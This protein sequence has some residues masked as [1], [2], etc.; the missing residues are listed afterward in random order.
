M[1]RTQLRAEDVLAIADVSTDETKK[2]TSEDLVLAGLENL[3]EGALEGNIIDWDSVPENSIDGSSIKDRSIEGVK[4]V[5]DTVTPAELQDNLPGTIIVNEGIDTAQLADGAVTEPKIDNGAVTTDKIA[6][7]AV[8]DAKITTVNGSKLVDGSVDGSKFDPNSF[9]GG[10]ELENNVVVHVNDVTAGSANGTVYD[11][12]GHV[13][14]STPILST[15]L[16]IATLTTPGAVSVPFEGGINVSANGAITHQN[17]VSAGTFAGITYDRHGHISA[18]DASGVVPPTSLPI[19]G[20]TAAE[21]GAVYI[22][23]QDHL[24]VAAD[25]AVRHTTVQGLATGTYTKVTVDTSGHVTAGEQLTASDIPNIEW[26]QINNIEI[27]QGDLGECAVESPNICDY[28]T[29]LMQ[30]TFPGK[31]DF[32]GQFWYTP[33]S[34]QLKVYSRG[35]GTEDLWLPVGFG[36][37]Q[38]QNLRVGFTYNATNQTI[39]SVTSYGTNVGLTAGSTVPPASEDLVGVYGVCVVA[40]NGMDSINNLS[41][42]THSAGD[43]ILCLGETQG[44]VHVDT[45]SSSGGSGGAQVLDDLLDVEIDYTLTYNLVQPSALLPVEAGQ[46]LTYNGTHWTNRPG[47][48]SVSIGVNPPSD[49]DPGDMWFDP[50][51]GQL[52]IW[53]TDNDSS[54]WVPAAPGTGGGGG[55]GPTGNTLEGLDDVSFT[56]DCPT[57]NG[58]FLKYN[59][60]TNVWQKTDTIDGGTF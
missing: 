47:G 5:L 40:G 8:T 30:E 16:P 27:G 10:I 18:V 35:S 45:N 12:H 4:L 56:A 7:G 39:V 11:E 33:S 3:P 26:D 44:W 36:A 2:I 14:G 37:L 29:C 42:T 43:W 57:D 13:T 15:E 6:D 20:D 46:V 59:C 24:T 9:G 17:N 52:F 21:L 50:E 48:G 55:G 41:G 34:A 28:A 31:G 53:Y 60:T 25:G 38:Q 23:V 49:A 54:Q 58:V 19:A 1:S 32:L 22:P 51:S